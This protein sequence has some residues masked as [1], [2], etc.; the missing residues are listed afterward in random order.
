[1]N[2]LITVIINV[3]NGET[4]INKCLDCIINQTYQNL[5]ILVVN[6]GSKDN[7]L[8]ILK[9]YKDKRIKII[10][11]KNLG[12][13]LSRNVGIDNAKGEYLYF[14][15]VDDFIELDTIEY[16]YKLCKENNTL[17]SSCRPKDVFDYNIKLSKSNEEI[18]VLTSEQMIKFLLLGKNRTGT[19]WN[20]LIHKS[21]FNN[22]RFENRIIN[23]VV[24][25]HKIIIEAKN[26]AYSNQIK[27]YYLRHRNSITG[28]E[29]KN[30]KRSIDAYKSLVE[31]YYYLK[32]I[33]PKM[34]ENEIC[35]IRNFVI[36]F[37]R[38][39]DKLQEYLKEQNVKKFFKKIFTFRV[40]FCDIKL[41]EK[42]KI[43]LF[44]IS[45]RLCR[46]IDR[47]YKSSYYKYKM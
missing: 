19:I 38:D 4:F 18:K 16:L 36:Y 44:L 14:I 17:M 47:K 46:I 33:Y 40:F 21:L 37:L 35:L 10:T 12:L 1:M 31:R 7:T 26:I 43:L 41:K 5:E 30:T 2:E 23:D 3:Y 24:V 27:Y 28:K 9:S 34:K 22:I 29:I 11:T 42:M 25:T 8:N 45:P 39:D 13:S 6:D 15:D 32:K 20:K